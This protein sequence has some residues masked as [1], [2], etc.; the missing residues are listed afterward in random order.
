MQDISCE[1][2]E[3]SLPGKDK[4][5]FLVLLVD[6]D[7]DSIHLIQKGLEENGFFRSE[8]CHATNM[9][10]ALDKLSK[11][12]FH[13]LLV[14]SNADA[15]EGFKLFQETRRLKL[16]IPFVMMAPVRD[17]AFVRQAMK[18]GVENIIVKSES[19]FQGLAQTLHECYEKFHS[20]KGIE[21]FRQKLQERLGGITPED[22]KQLSTR[23]D[24][25]GLY[26]HSYLHDRVVRDFSAATRYGYPLSCLMVDIDHF[27]LINEK[28]GYRT[29]EQILK[30]CGQLLFD[31]CRLSD[32]I[33][34]YG[35]EEFAIVLPHVNYEGASELAHRLR[36]LF[37]QHKFVVNSQEVQL[38]LSIGVAS[39]PEDPIKNRADLL[40]FADQALSRA[41]TLGRNSVSLYREMESIF[42]DSFPALKISEDKIV[43]FQR[44]MTE[45]SITARKAY[46][47]A[48]KALIA[49]LESKDRYTVGH[50]GSSA[51]YSLWTAEAMGLGTDE[52]EMV[53][54]AALL[55]DI[56]KICIPDAILLKP[57]RLTLT[58]FETMKQ[59]PY[60]G[61][62]MLKPVKFL[63]QEAIMVLHH[64][65]WWNGEGYPC[66]LKG[67]EI[68]LGAR[69]IAVVDSYDTMRTAGGRYKKTITVEYA[70]NELINCAGT[71]FDPEIVRVFIEVLKARGDLKPD[72]YNQAR[73][74]EVLQAN[75]TPA[76]KTFLQ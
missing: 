62:K 16:E 27:R 36:L 45:I 31:N 1:S 3:A 15:E 34:R 43:D 38:T 35:G 47:E 66:R 12:R 10:E 48:S 75:P 52:A 74:D 6:Q 20:R 50:A 54:H 2:E 57:G 68:P 28:F 9:E 40:V 18:A 13:L 33:A 22:K 53:Q 44:R 7:A 24:L 72:G 70:V 65:E 49:A 63:Q 61:Y 29:G 30:Q 73:L 58:E 11:H 37:A 41:K 8:V 69:I 67:N 26:T 60:L 19:H 76:Q 4:Q 5:S 17:D 64:H 25:T 59:H 42:G 71:Q 56:G 39:F 46:T 51:R 32:C 55:H 14:D 21:E 23:D